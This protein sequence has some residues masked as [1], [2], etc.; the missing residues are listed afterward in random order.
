[1]SAAEPKEPVRCRLLTPRGVGAIAVVR[2]SGA[3]SWELASAGA[4]SA[5]PLPADPPYGRVHFAVLHDPQGPIDDVLLAA[6]AD[7][8]GSGPCVDISCHGGRRVIERILQALCARG[9]VLADGPAVGAGDWR[10]ALRQHIHA[11]L[12]RATTARC[13]L[14][15][16]SQRTALVAEIERIERLLAAG[17]FSAARE[18]LRTLRARSTGSAYLARGATIAFVGAPNVGKSSLV[19]RLAG[20]EGALVS[21]Q[22]GTTRDWVTAETAFCGVPVTLIDTAG[23]HAAADALERRAIS[24]GRQRAAEA[25]LVVRVRAAT[26]PPA[27]PDGWGQ[28]DPAR[29]ADLAIVNKADL[30]DGPARAGER[31]RELWVSAL[32]GEGLAEFK[33]ALLDRLGVSADEASDVEPVVFDPEAREQLAAL[34][35]ALVGAPREAVAAL[36]AAFLGKKG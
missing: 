17:D 23:Q 9:A 33:L 18:A 34:E 11:A 27:G 14:F 4:E 8:D 28:D 35:R 25:D 1:M 15:L 22:A 16:L 5:R 26:D 12:A 3:G 2:V 24:A 7:A 31:P 6:R 30:V 32:T 19:N 36:G 29:P 20:R 13:A 10:G 21:G